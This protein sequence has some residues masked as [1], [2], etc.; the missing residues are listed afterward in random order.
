MTTNYLTNQQKTDTMNAKKMT[1]KELNRKIDIKMNMRQ[2][3]GDLENGELRLPDCHENNCEEC[4]RDFFMRN[5]TNQGIDKIG[6]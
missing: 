1:R 4:W 3:P 5:P 6:E 2:C